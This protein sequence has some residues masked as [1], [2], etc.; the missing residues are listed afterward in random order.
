M[1]HGFVRQGFD[2][3]AGID[4]D[5]TCRYA[6]EANNRTKFMEENIANVTPEMLNAEFG[7]DCDVKVLIGCAPCQPFSNTIIYYLLD[8]TRDKHNN[9]RS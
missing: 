9:L 4:V 3:V 8:N 1:T 2:V 7:E 6:Y 5:K